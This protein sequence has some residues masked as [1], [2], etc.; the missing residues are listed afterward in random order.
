[1]PPPRMRYNRESNEMF[2]MNI[3]RS[4]YSAGITQA[5]RNRSRTFQRDYSIKGP[6]ILAGASLSSLPRSSSSLQRQATLIDLWAGPG[7]R[8]E[9]VLLLEEEATNFVTKRQGRGVERWRKPSSSTPT[10]LQ[11]PLQTPVALATNQYQRLSYAAPQAAA[12]YTQRTRATQA[13]WRRKSESI[14]PTYNPPL[15]AH[16]PQFISPPTRIRAILL[17]PQPTKLVQIKDPQR[18]VLGKIRSYII[19][20]LLILCPR[21][22]FTATHHVPHFFSFQLPQPI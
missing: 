21:S 12:P 13:D 1:M 16:P 5:V 8:L 9:L 14:Q 10:L 2:T 22:P 3:G 20:P 11:L 17:Y 19:C 15:P 7:R 18:G 4:K 6:T